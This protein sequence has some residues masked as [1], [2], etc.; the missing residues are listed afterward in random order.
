MGIGRSTYWD[1]KNSLLLGGNA[2][3]QGSFLLKSHLDMLSAILTSSTGGVLAMT[4]RW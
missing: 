3:V 2:L 1:R 4:F